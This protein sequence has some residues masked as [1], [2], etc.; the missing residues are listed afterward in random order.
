MKFTTYIK[1]NS[2]KI[3]YVKKGAHELWTLD[4]IGSH[5]HPKGM[6]LALKEIGNLSTSAPHLT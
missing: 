5:R 2:Q 6:N 1:I 4:Q 3:M